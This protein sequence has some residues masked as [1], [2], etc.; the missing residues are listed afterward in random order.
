MSK[1]PIIIFIFTLPLFNLTAE[2]PFGDLFEDA[3]VNKSDTISENGNDNILD[4]G[5]DLNIEISGIL[6]T[7]L[8][9]FF[10]AHQVEDNQVLARPEA[11]VEFKVYGGETEGIISLEL[12]PQ[13]WI[14]RPET[15]YTD[16]IT[17]LYLRSF[18]DIGY[19]EAGLM[20]VE[21]GSADGIH[22]LDPLS[23]WDLSD[24]FSLDIISLK[25]AG[26]MIKMNMYIKDSGLL[27]VVYKPFFSSHIMAQEGRWSIGMENIP[28]LILPDTKTLEYSQAAL[29]L[30]S[31]YNR[32]DIGMQYYYGYL[33]DPGITPVYSGI[34]DPLDPGNYDNYLTYN[35][36]H[37]FGLE[38]GTSI[39]I[40]TFWLEAGYWLTGDLK[41]D[42]PT[43]YNNRFVY[44][45]GLDFTVP[46][47]K[48]YI[49][50]QLMGDYT[51]NTENISS[52]DVDDMSGNGSP[53]HNNMLLMAGEYSFNRD[54]TRVRLGGM[55][56]IEEEGYMILPELLWDIKD[57]LN[58]S[59]SGQIIE[60]KSDNPGLLNSWEAN[61]NLSVKMAFTY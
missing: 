31:T 5:S 27:E 55:W 51:F 60:G 21:W 17:E 2:D 46:K 22:V 58:L 36:A 49:N 44:L 11:E 41:G 48:F 3:E 56:S 15:V 23:Y 54:R 26:E 57:N 14:S 42:D 52:L 4:S 30:T 59:I 34:G 38:G 40:F 8:V 13:K 1:L 9:Y 45:P 16:I 50:L 12:S 39:G 24:G 43:V 20:K 53:S 10:D 28:N 32:F 18:F 37:L 29:R 6:S 35:K 47:T 33:P 7:E 61:D 25:K 19:L